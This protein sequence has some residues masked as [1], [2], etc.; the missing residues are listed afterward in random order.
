[1]PLSTSEP[2]HDAKAFGNFDQ[3]W[4][5]MLKRVKEET[6]ST[7]LKDLAKEIQD[8][9]NEIKPIFV[10]RIQKQWP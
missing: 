7:K 6:M 10:E 5:I 8:M 3:L 9:N 1:M 4:E 2:Q